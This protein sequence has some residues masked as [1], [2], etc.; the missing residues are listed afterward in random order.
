MKNYV[1]IVGIGIYLFKERMIVKEIFEKINGVWIEEV[2]IEK[3]GI[4][5]KVV[6]LLSLSDGI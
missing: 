3:L 6:F 2:V 4:K 1:G 5:I